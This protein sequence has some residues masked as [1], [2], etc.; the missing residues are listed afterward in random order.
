MIRR[1]RCLKEKLSGSNFNDWFRSLKLV[2]RVE[3]KGFI[4]EKLIPPAPPAGS[5]DQAFVDWNVIYDAHNENMGKTIGELHVLLIEIEKGLPKKAATPQVMAIQCGRIQK[6]NKKLLNAKGKGKGKCNGNE[7]LVYIS[8][9][10]NPKPFAKEHPTKDDACH[11]YKEV[12]HLIM[13]YLVKI[14]KKAR[15]LELKLRHLKI[16]V[17]TSYKPLEEEKARRHGKVYNWKIATYGKI[18]YEDDVHDLRSVETEF[19]AIVFNDKLTSEEALSCE[20]TPTVSYFDD[21]DYFKDFEKEFPAIVYNE[22]PAIVYNDTLTSKLDF[23]TELTLS[24]QHAIEFNLKD[25]TSLS[26]YDEEEQSVLYFNDLFPFNVIYS[27]DSKSNEDNDDK[28]WGMYLSYHADIMNF[29][30]ILGRIYDRGIHRVLVLDFESLP[31]V[32]S[33]VLTSRMLMEHRDDQGQSVF[34]SRA[35]RR[36]FEVRGPL[37][38]ELI[39]E[40]FSTFRFG[41]AIVDIDVVD[42]LQFQLGGARHRMS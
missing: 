7:K 28:P 22:F 34:T 24:P 29:E 15:I 4:I 35:W 20:P 40:F 37:V 42:M 33:E 39:M 2:L 27:D 38:F 32:M 23:L 17:L 13:E 6:A 30:E 5:T 9:P 41:E 11:H 1:C 12:G 25:E 8:K 21:L 10:K 19:P 36:L 16:T 26:E 3:K 31:A 14:S 18:W